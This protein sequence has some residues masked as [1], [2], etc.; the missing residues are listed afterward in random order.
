MSSYRVIPSHEEF[1]E[2][3]LKETV[4]K[5]GEERLVENLIESPPN[6]SSSSFFSC[7]FFHLEDFITQ[8][9]VLILIITEKP[10]NKFRKVFMC[11]VCDL[12]HVF[13]ISVETLTKDVQSSVQESYNLFTGL[14]I[15]QFL[16]KG[17]VFICF[18]E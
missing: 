5:V 18:R 11:V 8:L 3:P 4:P 14:G 12:L 17:F 1:V 13:R 9:V 6:W 2:E 15:V 7:F 16:D 10:I